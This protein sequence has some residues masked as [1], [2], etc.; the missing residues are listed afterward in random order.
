M[1]TEEGAVE[2]E[3]TTPSAQDLLNE[4]DSR[5]SVVTTPPADESEV[6]DEEGETV[7]DVEQTEET[8][9]P[10]IKSYSDEEF[11]N[12]L[13]ADKVDTKRLTVVQ[14]TALDF[15]R[16]NAEKH[17]TKVW[18]E[19]AEI[20]R[21]AEARIAETQ[22]AQSNPEEQVYLRYRENA[23]A[24]TEE[25]NAAIIQLED[26]TPSDDSYQLA[27]KNI[28]KLQAFKD[29]FALRRQQEGEMS[30]T[31]STSMLVLEQE[32]KKVI[33]DFDEKKPKLIEFAQNE[34]GYTAQE[35]NIFTNPAMGVAA[36]KFVQN[37]NK[38]YDQANAGKTAEK[39]RVK[40]APVLNRGNTVK[41]ETKR[42]GGYS[43]MADDDFE[44]RLA[45]VKAGT[46]RI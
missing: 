17:S 14:K 21:Q 33:K 34:L 3:E 23:L 7:E 19:A 12:D 2:V 5:Q 25:I 42:T 22:R 38:L 10:K 4:M 43:S 16:R 40:T 44:S 8:P 39:K 45:A 41:S 36:I 15:A 9:E 29:K 1:S 35:L 37:V 30:R 24:V 31:A 32:A 46:A 20:K 11:K 28:A 6:Q 13:D 27:R 18:Q 26:V